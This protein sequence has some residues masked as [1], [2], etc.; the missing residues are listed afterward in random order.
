MEAAKVPL[1]EKPS[2]TVI[3]ETCFKNSADKKLK[4]IVEEDLANLDRISE[5]TMLNVLEQRFQDRQFYTFVGDIL[6]A[7]NPNE[8]LDIFG[9][10][11][12]TVT[13]LYKL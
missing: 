1:K 11:V 3:I 4:K 13:C 8:L 12:T 5:K 6:I 2:E 9:K 7:L 10:K